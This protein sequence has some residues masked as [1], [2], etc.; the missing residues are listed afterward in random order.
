MPTK[1]GKNELI[2]SIKSLPKFELKEIYLEDGE[3][4]QRFKAVFCEQDGVVSVVTN[5]YSLVQFSEIFLPIIQ[6]LGELSGF[7]S[8]HFG[9]AIVGVF[10][11]EE[12]LKTKEGSLGILLMNSVDRSW[13]VKVLFAVDVGDGLVVLPKHVTGYTRKHIG[14][15]KQDIQGYYA[16]LNEAKNTWKTIVTKLSEKKLTKEDYEDIVSKIKLGKKLERKLRESISLE[17]TKINGDGFTLWDLFIKI[18]KLINTKAY[19]SEIHR[20][21][22]LRKVCNVVFEYAIIEEL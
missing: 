16:F 13:A 21:E 14:N 4:I 12:T 2:E 8:Y 5:R 7:V 9:K 3:S 19:K 18:I 15:I 10:P 6:E 17:Q 20:T 1:V 11:E 22:K